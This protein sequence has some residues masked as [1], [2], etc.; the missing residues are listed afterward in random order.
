MNRFT[1]IY[2]Q[3]CQLTYQAVYN[4]KDSMEVLLDQMSNFRDKK[5]AIFPMACNLLTVLAYDDDI[6][7]VRKIK[8]LSAWQNFRFHSFIINRLHVYHQA[9]QVA[10]Y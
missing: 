4:E 5:T 2:H 1:P 10:Y 9:G 7:Q 8:T 3:Q 6:K